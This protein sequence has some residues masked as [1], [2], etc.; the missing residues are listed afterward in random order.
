VK[1]LDRHLSQQQNFD[2]R[3]KR[4]NLDL[5]DPVAREVEGSIRKVCKRATL[6]PG[7]QVER[8]VP[9]EKKIKERPIDQLLER[10]ILKEET[11]KTD[12][13]AWY[14]AR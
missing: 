8:K 6:D 10:S 2:G 14:C 9:E 11:D 13:G 1:T 12:Y 3:G 4:S 5:N 7:R